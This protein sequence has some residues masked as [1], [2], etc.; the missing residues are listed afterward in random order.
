MEEFNIYCTIYPNLISLSFRLNFIVVNRFIIHRAVSFEYEE[1]S[2]KT[3]VDEVI[4]QELNFKEGKLTGE[5]KFYYHNGKLKS[6]GGM[7]NFRSVKTWKYFSPL[8]KYDR[9]AIKQ[10]SGIVLFGD[11]RVDILKY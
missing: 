2:S 3:I 5:Q 10:F 9:K 6:K 8:F 4:I 7:V 11:N 1:N